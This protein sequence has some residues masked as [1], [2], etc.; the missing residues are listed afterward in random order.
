MLLIENDIVHLYC[1]IKRTVSNK[2]YR[3]VLYYISEI[4]LIKSSAVTL[5]IIGLEIM[6][7]KQIECLTPIK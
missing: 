3:L 2:Y 6:G 4:Q 5:I 1:P 7:I